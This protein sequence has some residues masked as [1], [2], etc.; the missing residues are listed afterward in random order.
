MS[1]KHQI[2]QTKPKTK[3]VTFKI[4]KRASLT[5]N[6]HHKPPYLV[7]KHVFPLVHNLPKRHRVVDRLLLTQQFIREIKQ[8]RA[9][10]KI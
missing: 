10:V 3:K 7:K 8:L 5:Y 1:L 2:T 4:Q 9:D 6:K